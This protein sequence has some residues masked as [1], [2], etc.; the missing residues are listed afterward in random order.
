MH[1]MEKHSIILQSGGDE[2]WF[3]EGFGALLSP[4]IAHLPTTGKHHKVTG[5]N[6]YYRL[7]T[8]S[9]EMKVR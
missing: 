6:Y 9:P 4:F 1:E 3:L 8:Y 5:K 2:T 7:L